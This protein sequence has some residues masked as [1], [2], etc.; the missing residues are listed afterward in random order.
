MYY[1]FFTLSMLLLLQLQMNNQSPWI[2][3][4]ILLALEFWNSR[5]QLSSELVCL[6]LSKLLT[7][8]SDLNV[9]LLLGQHW[10]FQFIFL[11]IFT[12][13]PIG[14]KDRPD[15]SSFCPFYPFFSFAF[16]MLG[17]FHLL[18]I[19]SRLFF[20]SCRVFDFFWNK[21]IHGLSWW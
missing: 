15:H 19:I 11:K 14:Y 5:K 6:I 12:F 17:L 1:E 20:Q 10:P 18:S 16:L 9:H 2:K 7:V 4:I 21:F 13:R 3:I 8:T